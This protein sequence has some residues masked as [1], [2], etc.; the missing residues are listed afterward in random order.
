MSYSFGMGGILIAAVWGI[1]VWKEFQGAPKRT[2]WYLL[3][4]F[5]LFIV[6]IA[7]IAWAKQTMPSG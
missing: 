2:Y 5:V 7:I 1:F 3:G 4:M 6:G